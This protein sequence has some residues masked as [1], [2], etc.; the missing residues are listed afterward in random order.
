MK[1]YAWRFYLRFLNSYEI[2]NL[3]SLA[4]MRIFSLKLFY[5]NLL[6]LEP[7]KSVKKNAILE[8]KI[9]WYKVKVFV[10]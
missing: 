2:W 4:P 9:L 6:H 7:L 5:I 8:L 10:H 3:L 1:S